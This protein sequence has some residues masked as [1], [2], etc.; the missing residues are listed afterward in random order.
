MAAW[1]AFKG[2]WSARYPEV[3][4][5]WQQDLP[6]LLRLYDYPKPKS[7]LVE[8]GAYLRTRSKNGQRR[9][10]QVCGSNEAPKADSTGLV[11][12]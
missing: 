9:T 3:V 4:A 6:S 5:S 10:L 1:E 7:S 11:R 12:L 2:R 8:L